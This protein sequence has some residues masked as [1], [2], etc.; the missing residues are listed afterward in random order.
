[1][2]RAA[3]SRREQSTMTR[4]SFI[5]ASTA[6]RL[7]ARDVGAR[8]PSARCARSR[9]IVAPGLRGDGAKAEE[10]LVLVGLWPV[11]LRREHADHAVAREDR[12]NDTG[13][14]RDELPGFCA[15]QQADLGGL[16]GP[17]DDAR[18]TGADDLAREAFPERE[19]AAL[20]L[21]APIDLTN[22]VH[23]LAHLVV[24]SEEEDGRIHHTRRLVVER[25][26]QLYE[27]ARIG[28]DR[29]EST[30]E[31]ESRAMLSII[32]GRRLQHVPHSHRVS[33]SGWDCKERTV[34]TLRS[35]ARS[36][37]RLPR[38]R[39]SREAGRPSSSRDWSQ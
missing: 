26:E 21:F 29:A 7:R 4:A 5:P 33:A 31:L 13:P 37:G 14:R 38:A 16:A 15:V 10:I 27:V 23:R 35:V 24:Q 18:R 32:Y 2:V 11:A 8:A 17:M 22:D 28:R 36:E 30:R 39:R 6:S 19:R 34:V 3:R 20:V 1:M 9:L 12:N 25:A